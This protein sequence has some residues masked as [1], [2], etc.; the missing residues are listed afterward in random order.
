MI[1][2]K[3]TGMSFSPNPNDS[4]QLST[5]Q[6]AIPKYVEWLPTASSEKA[7]IFIWADPGLK[8]GLAHK[9]MKY[10]WLFEHR[11]YIQRHIDDI[12]KNLEIYKQNY[13]YI[14]T[15]Q[16][17]LV[18]MG[19]P[20]AYIIPQ[21]VPRVFKDQRKI[22]EKTK[23]V[24]T[25]ITKT[26]TG[27]PGHIKRLAHLEKNKNYMDVYGR[28][29]EVELKYAWDGYKDYM[30]TVMMENVNNDITLSPTLTD[31]FAT[32]TVP[33]YW[34]SKLGVETYFD[35]EGVLWVD[36]I[37]LET[38][39]SEELYYN[40]MPHIKINLDIVCNDVITP[41]DYICEQFLKEMV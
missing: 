22:Y 29:R 34:G 20:F 38:D 36:D 8:Q 41:E 32:G 23:L 4:T 15:T 24:S 9:G 28:G 18:E 21:I 35:P 39:L 37:N 16:I 12:L 26:N 27:M 31:A 25:V 10:G 17:D 33:I 19:H 6:Y 30:F 7:D 14:F 2:F 5:C 3:A 11:G 1:K 13:L 40:M